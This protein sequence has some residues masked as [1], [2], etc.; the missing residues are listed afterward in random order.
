M[1]REGRARGGQVIDF[2][3]GY[4]RNCSSNNSSTIIGELQFSKS[5]EHEFARATV[6]KITETN[7]CFVRF[8]VEGSF[9]CKGRVSVK[10]LTGW[11]WRP[12]ALRVSVVQT[13]LTDLVSVNLALFGLGESLKDTCSAVGNGPQDKGPSH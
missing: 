7:K 5:R 9:S 10:W 13:L 1:W 3:S 8:C 11:I 2:Q 6:A 12:L 4:L